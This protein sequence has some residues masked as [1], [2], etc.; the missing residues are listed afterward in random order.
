MPADNE[1]AFFETLERKAEAER[2]TNLDNARQKAGRIR[3][4]AEA[5]ALRRREATLAEARNEAERRL[6]VARD[7][8]RTEAERR[9]GAMVHAVANEMLEEVEK[10]LRDLVSQPAFDA[11]FEALLQESVAGLEGGDYVLEVPAD[12]ADPTREWLDRQG[13]ANVEVRAKES[14]KDGVILSDA[15]RTFRFTNT[16]SARL[17]R[18]RDTARRRCVA[19][20]CGRDGEEA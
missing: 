10:A 2:E 19:R 15:D 9:S 18:V 12:R 7:H 6:E 17:D 20:L 4:E 14:L 1:Q 5:E 3:S 13:T 8:A 16:L 11:V